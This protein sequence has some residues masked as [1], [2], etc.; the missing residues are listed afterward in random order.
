MEVVK[1]NYG[2]PYK[3]SKNKIAKE[4]IELFP[5]AENFY[6]L[7][8]GGCAITHAALES[9]K[10][11]TVIANDIDGR[12]PQLFLDAINGNYKN[13]KR[14]ISREIFL[15]EKDNDGYIASVWSFGNDCRN[16]MYSKQIEPYKKAFH[17]ACFNDY[18][19]FLDMGIELPYISEK[20]PYKRKL[21]IGK[22]LTINKEEVKEKYIQW[23]L[24]NIVKS[25]VEYKRLVKNSKNKIEKSE[26]ELRQYLLKALKNSG[27]TQAEVGRLLRTQMQRHYFGKSQWAFPTREMYIKMQ[28]FMP[29]E[30]SY[31]EI[32]GLQDLLEKLQSL[33]SLENM[34]RI[35]RLQISSKDYAEV[36]VKPNSVM[37]CDIPYEGTDE[38]ISGSFDYKRFFDWAAKQ[39]NIF[40]SS[41]EI[42]DDRFICI[43]EKEKNRAYGKGN[44]K[45][46]MERVYIRR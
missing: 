41:E 22:Y 2:I 24:K 17:F 36:N 26:D 16:Y 25:D 39:K 30:K 33:G 37:Y 5:S 44:G 10:F 11:K 46:A 42:T 21:A 3:G 20:E 4:I 43:F 1:I 29:L 12:M 6:D 40:I 8:C 9:N 13:E 27:L 15:K 23:Y 7:F 32:Y 45:Y 35:E 14:W 31:D 18:N 38:Y 34:E 19:L 28:E